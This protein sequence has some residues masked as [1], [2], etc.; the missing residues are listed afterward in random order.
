MSVDR[1]A[2]PGLVA[3][4]HSLWQHAL[5]PERLLVHVVLLDEPQESLLSYLRCHNL[6]TGQVS[7]SPSQALCSSLMLSVLL[8]LAQL[9]VTELSSKQVSPQRRVLD[10]PDLVG[11]LSSAANFARFQFPNL[12]PSLHRALYLDV[13][14]VVRGDI[15]E[16][17][18]WLS[19]SDK[20]M[21]AVP[22]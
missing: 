1:Q 8:S 14:T 10:P 7:T 12:F 2:F 4:L 3:A 17:W 6:P 20:L 16:L 22:R 9:T 21:M 5:Q 15:T 18:D 19:T 11:N 13:D